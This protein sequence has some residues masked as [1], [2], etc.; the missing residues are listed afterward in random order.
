[1]AKNKTICVLGLGYIGLPTACFLASS[2]YKVIGVDLDKK[3]INK[4]KNKQLPFEEPG[5]QKIFQKAFKNTNFSVEIQPADVFIIAVPTPITN[6]KK[7]DLRFVKQAA[8]DISR[9]LK[10]GNL[11]IIESTIPP[12]TAERVVLPILKKKDKNLQVYLS[13]APERAI[14]GRTIKE[15]AENDRIIGGIDNKS[16]ELTKLIY[17]SFVKGKIYLTN[18][19]TAEFVKLIENSFRDINIA[20]ANELAKLCDNIHINVW[21]AI[22]L[23]NLHPRVNIHLPG[24]GVGGH[25]LAI[26]PWFLIKRG[27]NGTKFIKLARNINDSM[28][29]YVV[30]RVAE[31]LKEIKKPTVTIL[32]VAY[33]ADVD[34]WRETPALKIIKLAKKKG[35]QVEIHDP[36][37]NDFPYK[38]EKDFKKTTKGSDCIVLIT[39]HD[40]YKTINPLEIKNMRE[41]NIF[42][43]RN[44]INEQKWQKAGF[45]TKILGKD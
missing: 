8:G 37:V 28:P 30:G 38:I 29:D 45:K 36:Y 9:V 7:A 21:E 16:A 25:C 24:P 32:G 5:L 2:G 12:G 39:D 31:M 10:N 6:N 35:W 43:A 15:M 1:M 11:V 4:L 3:K 26:D 20:F 27:V 41:K 17:S 13:H 22:K 44:S 18:A 33:K 34:D 40:F 14:P 19:T 42:D 23:A